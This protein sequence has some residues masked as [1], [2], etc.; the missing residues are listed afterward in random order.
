MAFQPKD[1]ED[2]RVWACSTLAGPVAEQVEAIFI[3]AFP[4]VEREPFD[5]LVRS[6]NAGSRWLYCASTR[7]GVIGFSVIRPLPGSQVV[8]LEYCATERTVRGRGLGTRLLQATV[9][10]LED[11]TNTVAIVL[12]VESDEDG[13]PDERQLKA[14][15]I[16]FYQRNGARMIEAVTK[17][18]MPNMTGPGSIPMRLLWL[19][20]RGDVELPQG[21]GLKDLVVNIYRNAYH[22]NADDSLVQAILSSIRS[23][24]LRLT[25]WSDFDHDGIVE[26]RH[27]RSSCLSTYAMALPVPDLQNRLARDSFFILGMENAHPAEVGKVIV[28]VETEYPPG[29]TLTLNV[30][31]PARDKV[32]IFRL[33][34]T[35][36]VYLEGDGRWKMPCS[37]ELQDGQTIGLVSRAFVGEQDWNGEFVLE[38]VIH[39][40]QG[41]RL[42]SDAVAFRTAPFVLASALDR[43]ESVLVVDNPR[44]AN[45]T[46]AL[47]SKLAV[48]GVDLAKVGIEN[49][50]ENDV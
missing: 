8:L 3:E 49:G 41:R 35:R 19:P 32:A 12:E 2:I 27:E 16:G 37:A 40:S 25:L 6:I 14:R 13:S 46:A 26:L 9:R 28:R 42:A 23:D 44:S 38:A 10:H 5:D 7:D 18:Q 43:P 31:G 29:S 11:N 45:L 48:L 47:G 15:R 36:W 1:I 34:S 39:D 24:C 50:F 21:E 22:R 20:V 30:A 4:G 17:Y 33:L